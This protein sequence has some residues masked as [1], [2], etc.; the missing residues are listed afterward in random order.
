MFGT[1]ERVPTYRTRL[2]R[3]LGASQHGLSCLELLGLLFHNQ[4]RAHTAKGK[5]LDAL[6]VLGPVGVCVVV[7]AALI[8]D[9]LKELDQVEGLF[10]VLRVSER[11]SAMARI[12]NNREGFG[13]ADDRVIRR[14]HEPMPDGPLKGQR[15]DPQQ[16]QAA[17]E[18]YYEISGW[19]KNGQPTPGKLVD[20]N[21]EWLIEG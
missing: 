18:L 17:V 16:F 8:A 13:P 12:F 1:G 3:A 5:V 14:W 15:I 2:L 9:I 10:E 19:D 4:V 21:L 6:V 20:L 11:S 7:A